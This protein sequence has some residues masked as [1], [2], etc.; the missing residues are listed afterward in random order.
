M[1]G[2]KLRHRINI[3]QRYTYRTA[4]GA[5]VHGWSES[6][7]AYRIHAA[8][9]P[10]SGKE[11]LQA[12]EIASSVN[13]RIRI[14]YR[15]GIRPD[16]RVSHLIELKGEDP[17]AQVYNIIAVIHV[18]SRQREIHLMCESLDTATWEA[19]DGEQH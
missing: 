14:R 18:E 15:P 3:R 12:A 9:E 7:F 13:T 11:L 2:G 10:L 17:I 5:T 8:I 1:K 19:S 16:M 6:D 4:S